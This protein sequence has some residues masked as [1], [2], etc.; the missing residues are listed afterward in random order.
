[1]TY[2]KIVPC[3]G[4]KPPQEQMAND[5]EGVA[6]LTAHDVTAMVGGRSLSGAMIAPVSRAMQ[7]PWTSALL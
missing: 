2:T 3:L 5:V 1:M 6:N 7:L 4:T